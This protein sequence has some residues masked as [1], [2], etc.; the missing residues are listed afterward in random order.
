MT[1]GKS[2]PWVCKSCGNCCISFDLRVLKT[3]VT[4]FDRNEFFKA[5]GVQFYEGVDGYWYAH[6]HQQCRHLIIEGE[7][8]IDPGH[9]AC[10]IYALRPN[11]CK[12][13]SCNGLQ[14]IW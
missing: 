3:E 10:D 14:N 8:E 4:D 5:R 11:I 12:Q 13:F 9:W 6:I 7:R 2:E 1:T